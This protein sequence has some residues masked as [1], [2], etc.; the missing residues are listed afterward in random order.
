MVGGAARGYLGLDKPTYANEEAYRT[1]QAIGNMPGFGAPAGIFK[2]A[3]NAPEVIAAL[4]GLLGKGVGKVVYHGS[5]RGPII[6]PPRLAPHDETGIPGFSV[7]RGM[8]TA[9]SYAHDTMRRHF[10]IDE[11][12][13]TITPFELKGRVAEYG[14][15]SDRVRNHYKTEM[16]TLEQTLEYAKKRRVVGLDHSR[17]LNIDEISVLFPEALRRVEF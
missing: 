5:P 16:P 2:A 8:R 1:A 11:I 13:P 9:E 4:G 6:G 17:N 7:S 3:A 10:D 14:K 15:F 12:S